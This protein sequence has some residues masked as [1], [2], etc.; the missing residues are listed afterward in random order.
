MGFADFGSSL[1]GQNQSAG[2][3]DPA[4]RTG[5]DESLDPTD[6][7]TTQIG[8][9]LLERETGIEPATLSLGSFL[10]NRLTIDV[11]SRILEAW[12]G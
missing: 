9:D 6:F 11:C 4:R 10:A 8:R 7:A 2:R 1:P 12:A 5:N 3:R